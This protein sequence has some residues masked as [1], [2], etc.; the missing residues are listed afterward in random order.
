MRYDP[1]TGNPFP[2]PEP[3][4]TFIAFKFPKKLIAALKI[5]QDS[6]ISYGLKMRWV[7]PENTHLTLKF[8]GTVDPTDLGAIT[9]VLSETAGNYRP[10]TYSAKGLGAFPGIN[11]P[12]VVWVGLSGEIARI[13]EFQKQLDQGLSVLGYPKE[14]RPFRGHLTIG[15]IKGKIDSKALFDAVRTFSTFPSE[16]AIADRVIWFK[17]DLRPSGAV[18]TELATAGLTGQM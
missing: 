10:F 3:L 1:F 5:V 2:M 16:P 15:R 14:S 7:R 9:G 4:R 8:L 12:R 6:L 18:Y 13:A 17:S 11:R